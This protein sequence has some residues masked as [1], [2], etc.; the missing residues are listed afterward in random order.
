MNTLRACLD[1][2]LS[3]TSAVARGEVLTVTEP[4]A[5]TRVASENVATASMLD[6]RIFSILP[7]ASAVT[8][9]DIPDGITGVNQM[10]SNTETN[11]ATV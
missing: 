9:S 11:P 3:I 5:V 2:S 4:W 1:T 6:A 8:R 10:P 7:T